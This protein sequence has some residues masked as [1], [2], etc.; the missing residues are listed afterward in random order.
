MHLF[1]RI[2]GILAV[3]LNT[4]SSFASKNESD[5]LEFVIILWYN[6]IVKK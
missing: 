2:V 5:K 1:E 6:L 4:E 3:F